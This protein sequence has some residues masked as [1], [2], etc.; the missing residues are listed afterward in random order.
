MEDRLEQF[1]SQ[2]VKAELHLH[3]EGCIRLDTLWRLARENQV[4][5]AGVSSREDLA[6][7]YRIQN[8]DQF[9]YFFI[10]VLQQCICR[11][12]DIGLCFA[13]LREY[14][15]RNQVRYAELF[16]SPSKLLFKGIDYGD[17]VEEL[18]NGSEKLAQE[19]YICKFLIDV[20]R[21]FGPENAMRNLNY[22]LSYPCEAVIGIGLGGSEQDGPAGDYVEVFRRARESRLR[23][24]AHAGEDVG[25]ESVWQSIELLKAERIGHGTSSMHDAELR[26]EIRRRRIPLEIC[27]TS[28]TLTRR[29]VSVAAEH[30]V[31]L[32]YEEG[33]PVT[34]HSDDPALFG[35]ELNDEYRVLVE[36][37]GFG[38]YDVLCIMENNVKMS[39]MPEQ[40][41]EHFIQ[42]IRSTARECGII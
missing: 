20:S 32:F 33:L 35:S 22:V 25:P 6:R 3:L 8:L 26:T 30:P 21:S 41:K 4:E 39:F 11:A 37:C 1:V 12:Q 18:Q 17:I 9:V 7:L 31:R 14:M 28:N 24:V 16:F 36:Q 13:D 10:N 2:V 27:I 42:N 23:C 15:Q 5:I 19:G 40:N 34:L 38:A 29:F